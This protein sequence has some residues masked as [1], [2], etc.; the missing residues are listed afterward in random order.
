MKALCMRVAIGALA[1]LPIATS[2]AGETTYSFSWY[3][4]PT[5]ANFPAPMTLRAGENGFTYDGFAEADGSDLRVKDAGG[6]LLPHEIERWDP[7]GYSIVWVKLPSIS[8]AAMTFS[9]KAGS[10]IRPAQNTGT[11]TNC[12]I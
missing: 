11:S 2:L 6:N 8:P 1:A 9:A 3:A 4:G 10:S 12:L 5:V 7:S